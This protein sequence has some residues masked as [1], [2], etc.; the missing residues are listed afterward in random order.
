MTL[1]NTP[2]IPIRF[3]KN[4]KFWLLIVASG[5]TAIH[6]NL[7]H[8]YGDENLVSISLVLLGA[9]LFISWENRDELEVK[10]DVLSR[11]IGIGIIAFVMF[12]SA[13]IS[14]LEPFVQFSP[15]VSAIGL[16]LCASGLKG[17][18]QYWQQLALL[19]TL[20]IPLEEIIPH[21]VDLAPLTA[22]LSATMLWCLGFGA[23]AQG[24]DV[25]LPVGPPAEVS[26]HCTGLN[27]ISRLL[28][29]SILVLVMFPIT[30]VKSIFVPVVAVLIAFI[31]NGVRVAVLTVFVAHSQESSFDF[32]HGPGG[33]IFTITSVVIFGLFYYL[34]SHIDRLKSQEPVEN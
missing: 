7:I 31:G 24:I 26:P 16:G 14:S 11:L 28:R 5:L 9:A 20:A 6:L 4:T 30:W 34:I 3:R 27:I 32:F 12:R 18:R 17:L 23:H 29:L 19:L 1:K 25:F 21:I 10:S 33:H 2:I 13:Y 8:K 15:L 22:K